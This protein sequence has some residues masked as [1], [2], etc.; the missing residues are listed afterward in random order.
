VRE[1]AQA[2]ARGLVWTPRSISLDGKNNGKN[3]NNIV[4]ANLVNVQ[5]TQVQVIQEVQ[6]TQV[7]QNIIVIDGKKE[8]RDN[9]RK[10]HYRNKN[11]NVVCHLLKCFWQ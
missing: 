11:K 1:P 7:V 9:V 8:A 5:L 4:I 3:N 6:I 10:N 2:A